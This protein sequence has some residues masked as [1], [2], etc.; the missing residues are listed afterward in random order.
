MFAGRTR[1]PDTGQ[2][3][4]GYDSGV[5]TLAPLIFMENLIRGKD[6]HILQK[7]SLP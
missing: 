6:F 4:E 7:P 5:P 2:Q 1:R 3:N